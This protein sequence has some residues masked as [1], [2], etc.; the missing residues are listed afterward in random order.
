MLKR[1]AVLLCTASSIVLAATP[2][3]PQVRPGIGRPAIM[4]ESELRPGM[5]G[6]A[7]TVF[8]GTE[9][10][11]VPIEILGVGK[12]MWGPRQDIILGKMGGN[13]KITNVAGGMSGS[14]V[15]IDGKL[16]GAVAL[17]LSM[18]SPDADLRHHPHRADARN[19]RVR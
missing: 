6:V 10:E 5:T 3:A 12:N 1:V 18:F 16:V 4:K 2:A 14:P 19:Q 17:R 11:A 15:Y 7:W 9:P 8:S 13:A